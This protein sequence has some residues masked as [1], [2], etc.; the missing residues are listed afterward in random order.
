MGEKSSVYR[1]NPFLKVNNESS[2]EPTP[3]P[4]CKISNPKSAKCRTAISKTSLEGAI[5]L[6]AFNVPPPNR[7]FQAGAVKISY[8]V[9]LMGYRYKHLLL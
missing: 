7:Y 2:R 1:P 9:F 3:P 6:K 5:L 8:Q 4:R